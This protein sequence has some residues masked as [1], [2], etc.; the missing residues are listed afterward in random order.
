MKGSLKVHRQR[1]TNNITQSGITEKSVQEIKLKTKKK[2]LHT[3]EVRKESIRESDM[4]DKYPKNPKHDK[5]KPN[6]S[7]S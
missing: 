2:T 1:N 5:I 6:H 7:D 4:W 3:K